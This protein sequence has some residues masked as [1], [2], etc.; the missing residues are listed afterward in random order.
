MTQMNLS[1]KQRWTHTENRPVVAKEGGRG[2]ME[3]EVGI[4]R[5]ELLYIEWRDKKVLLYSTGNYIHYPAINHNG[6]EYERTDCACMYNWIT[7][8][9]S[10]NMVN[11][12]YFNKK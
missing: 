6:K 8:L 11:Q 5:Y 10:N 9:Q 1:M 12:L 7:L 3:L 2:G 4:S